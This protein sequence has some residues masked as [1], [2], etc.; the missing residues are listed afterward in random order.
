MTSWL[1]ALP[2]LVLA[3]TGSPAPGTTGF[4]IESESVFRTYELRA[5]SEETL[6]FAPFSQSLGLAIT[7]PITRGH[8]S[9]RTYFRGIG[10]AAFED[11]QVRPKIYL[12]HVDYEQGRRYPISLR[13]GRQVHSTTSRFFS[14][15]GLR[16]RYVSPTFVAAEVYGGTLV[17]SSSLENPA[18][19]DHFT[20]G[21]A[22]YLVGVTGVQGR[23]SYN[24]VASEEGPE[25]ED[26]GV[27][28]AYKLNN[29]FRFYGN[30][31]LST[32]LLTLD[33]ALLG[34]TVNLTR[35]GIATDVEAFRYRPTFD[36][37]SIYNLFQTTGFHEGRVRL[38]FPLRSARTLVY[39]RVGL[40]FFEE[41]PGL[42]GTAI[43]VGAGGRTR[44]TR[45]LF[46]R[47]NLLL[48]SGYGGGRVGGSVELGAA[49]L[50]QRLIVSGGTH[51]VNATSE[52]LTLN[53]GTFVSLF[54][55]ARMNL[56]ERIELAFMVED[57]ASDVAGNRVRATANLF[58]RWDTFTQPVMHS[59]QPD[60]A[61]RRRKPRT[62][63]PKRKRRRR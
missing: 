30:A 41:Q 5:V 63:A 36:A 46:T 15:D 21:G 61:R 6:L 52:T 31:N 22:L 27:D 8:V 11:A 34:T 35:G 29:R 43:A 16:F 33:E 2:L 19:F 37:S 49:L 26:V 62:G 39:T 44:F 53:E 55:T 7:Q 28:F 40:Q 13:L 17:N 42:D 12:A 1:A 47:Y 25:R 18:E 58:L 45:S 54:A 23:L 59:A 9:F 3:Q 57:Q 48:A 32:L 60:D 14:F 24:H 51:V 4:E 50:D 20:A 10:D 56:R 38:R